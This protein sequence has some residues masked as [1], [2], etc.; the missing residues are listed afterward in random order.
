MF[1]NAEAVVSKY[2]GQLRH[3]SARGT[4]EIAGERYIL[5]R[6]ASLSVEFFQLVSDLFGEGRESEADEFARNILFDLSHA[7]GRSDA[8][9]FHERT[10][11]VDPIARLSAGPVHFAY[12]GWA[13]V[14]LDASSRPVASDEFYLL[15]DHPYSFESDAWIRAGR[16]RSSPACIMNAGYSSGWCE[17]SFGLTLVATELQCRACGDAHCRFVMAPPHRIEAYLEPLRASTRPDGPLRQPTPDFFVRKRHEEELRRA[18]DELEHRVAARTEELR[19]SNLRLRRE[20]EERAGIERQLRQAHKLEALG[21]LAG[22]VA[23][24]FNTLLGV[25]V[26]NAALL[27]KGSHDPERVASV[28]AILAASRQAAGLTRRLLAFGRAEPVDDSVRDVNR[29]LEETLR[30]LARVL[31]ADIALE[32]RFDPSVAGARIERSQLEQ[33]V[34]NLVINARDAMPAG[35]VLSLGTSQHKLAGS[36]AATLGLAPGEYV[37]LSVRDDGIGMKEEVASRVFEPYFTTKDEYAGT[38]LGLSTVYGYA[39]ATGGTVELETSPG[40]GATFRV[41]VPASDST[42]GPDAAPVRAPALEA[43]EETVLVVEEQRALRELVAGVLRDA[44]YRVVEAVSARHALEIA[45]VPRRIELLVSSLATRELTGPQLALRLFVDR[46]TLRVLFL[47]SEEAPARPRGDDPV[48]PLPV[49]PR[50]LLRRVRAALA[51]R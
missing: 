31:G 46:P 17:E 20:M 44:G 18:H 48:V 37:C 8:R 51:D 45:A 40:Q 3:D 12:A 7:I 1:E 19:A 28:E 35:G 13:S 41:Y 29:V 16:P 38:G 9:N 25:I 2:F 32:V 22:G 24:D 5:V 11:A 42:S 43:G 27:A 23:H 14:S 50:E 47:G 34:L 33:I 6:A 39:V 49:T 15:Y 30:L 10:G 4:I 21:R 36:E 26:G